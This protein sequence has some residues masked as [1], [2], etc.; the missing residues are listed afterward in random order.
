MNTG[1]DHSVVDTS[2]T[3]VMTVQTFLVTVASPLGRSPRGWCS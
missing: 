1:T 3:F 2:R